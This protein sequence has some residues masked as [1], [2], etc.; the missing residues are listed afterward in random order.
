MLSKAQNSHSRKT[1][2]KY[3]AKFNGGPLHDQQL[4][5]PKIQDIL[6]YTKIYD[7]GLKTLSKYLLRKVKEDVLYF[8]IMEE[9][10]L[11]YSRHMERH[12][13]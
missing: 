10:F 7:S 11:D 3:T 4:P 12:P 8:D 6:E 2:S 13:R 1:M 9:R 5:L